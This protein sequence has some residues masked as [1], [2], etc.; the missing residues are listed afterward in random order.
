MKKEVR[1]FVEKYMVCQIAKGTTSNIRLYTPL[2][3]PSKPWDSISMDFVLGL[4]RTRQGYD[5][6]YVV[7]DR[8]SKMTHLLPCKTSH[9]A[10]HIAGILF[11]EIVR[12]HGLPLSIVSDRDPIFL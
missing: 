6:I 9:D 3:I 8:F 4:P 5:S 2:P 7:V 1:I 12:L 11:K 10:S